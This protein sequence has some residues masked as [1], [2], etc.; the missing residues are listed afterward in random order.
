M[1]LEKKPVGK[2]THYFDHIG[3]GVLELSDTLQEGDKISVEL[4][5]GSSFEQ[6]VSSMQINKQPVRNAKKGDDVGLKLA[7]PCRNATV[8]KVVG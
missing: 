4:S 2:I 8:Y 1:L 3:V 6:V 7:Q 5:D